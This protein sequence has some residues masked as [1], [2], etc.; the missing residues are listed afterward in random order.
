MK[1][2]F[3]RNKKI[4][5]DLNFCHILQNFC[6][7]IFEVHA[8]EQTA[9]NGILSVRS[10]LTAHFI[11]LLICSGNQGLLKSD[12]RLSDLKEGIAQL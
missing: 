4:H 12:E 3:S 9:Q 8:H 11:K 6:G 2:K 10:A 1:R 7:S 5:A